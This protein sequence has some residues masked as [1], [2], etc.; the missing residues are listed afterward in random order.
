MRFARSPNRVTVPDGALAS[1]ASGGILSARYRLVTIASFA[2]VFLAAFENLAVATVM[3]LISRQL[4]GASLY[5]V[6]FSGPLAIGVVGMVIAGTWTDRRGPRTPLIALVV[7]FAAGLVIAG[8]APSMAV[9]VA[10]RLLYGL[11]GGGIT[12]VLYVVVGRTYPPALQPQIFGSFAVAWILPALIGPAIAGLVAVSVGWRWVFLGVVVLV[13]LALALVIPTLRE[14]AGVAGE[15]V[16]EPAVRRTVVAVVLALAILGLGLA[17][18]FHGLIELGA[19]I[20]AL[21][22]SALCAR[23][24]LPVGTLRL[25]AGIGGVIGVRA[26]VAGAY[27]GAEIYLPYLLTGQFHLSP[28]LSGLSLTGAGVAWG[29]ASWLQGRFADRFSARASIQVGM[30]LVIV[31]VLAALATAYFML[32][33]WL[34]IAGWTVGGVGMGMAYPRLSVLMLEYST[35]A[36]QGFNSSALAIADSV[37][38]AIA[39]AVLGIVFES[40]QGRGGSAPAFSAVFL[41]SVLLAGVAVLATPRAARSGQASIS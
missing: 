36:T 15:P 2:I 34:A 18:E 19:V 30:V 25:R 29:A 33:P 21:A 1:A 23:F 38:P 8:F 12:V 13:V 5:A 27:F 32:S 14:I 37:G 20:V 10:G 6:A 40:I 7:V 39:L 11:A 4:H 26:I 41:L 16:R 3:P 22:V 9:L 31:A 24:L 35:R 28:A 17:G